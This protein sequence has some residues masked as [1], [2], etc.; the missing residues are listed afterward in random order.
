MGSAP[1]VSWI[2]TGYRPR[3]PLARLAALLFTAGLCL[4]RPAKAVV[5][6]LARE[7]TK[8][9]TPP[10]MKCLLCPVRAKDWPPMAGMRGA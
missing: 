3:F 1:T 7:R 5:A 6:R 8:S 2:V 4:I 9:R 10:S